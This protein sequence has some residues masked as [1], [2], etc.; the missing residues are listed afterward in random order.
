MAE[1]CLGSPAGRI[2]KLQAQQKKV[3][4][5]RQA[6]VKETGANRGS[7]QVEHSLV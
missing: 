3:C 2:S 5:S 1:K 7:A 4:K 6:A